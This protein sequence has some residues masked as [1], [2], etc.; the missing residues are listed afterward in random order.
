MKQILSA[1]TPPERSAPSA[2]PPAAA[3]KS[4]DI[5]DIKHYFHV[6]VKRIWLVA[7]CFAISVSVTVV[8]LVKQV[9]RYR[10]Q[11]V[12]LMSKGLPLP[13]SLRERESEPLGDYVG[14]QQR[15]INSKMLIKRARERM[16]RPSAEIASSIISVA[17]FPIKDTAFMVVQVD[18]YDPETGADYANALVD[19]YLVFKA[20]QRRDT[21]QATVTSLSEQADRL[22]R[23]LQK[24]EQTLVSFA[25]E[26]SVVA[27]NNRGNIAADILSG[28]TAQSAQIKKDRMLL[29]VQ[30]PF[31]GRATDDVILNALDPLALS[32]PITTELLNTGGEDALVAAPEGLMEYGVVERSGWKT[33][34]KKQDMLNMKLERARKKYREA[35]PYIQ[36]TLRELEEVNQMMGL[37]V[38]YAMKQYYSQLEA[39]RIKEESIKRVEQS[40]E[41]QAIEVNKK[42]QE[43][44]SIVRQR[45]RLQ[46][47][48]DLI[49]NR[50]KEVDIS[51]GIEPESV[52]IMERAEPAMGPIQPRK[53]QSLFMAALVGI[54]IGLGLVFGLEYIDD[55]LK[56][57]D[58]VSLKLGLRF[59]GV[60]P[61]AKWDDRDLRTHL[62]SNIDQKSGLAEAYRNF[63]SAFMLTEKSFPYKTL[64]ITSAVP[65]E[66]KT[67][68]CMNMGVTLAQAG[69]RI[70]LVDADLRRGGVHKFFGADARLGFAD[71]LTGKAK[72]EAVIQHTGIPNLDIVAAGPYPTNPAEVILKAERKTF[73]DYVS[74]RYDRILFDCP[75]VMATSEASILASMADGVIFVV[76]A[77]H[78]SQ[79]LA[80]MSVK[81]LVERGANMVG[82][83]LN[84]L[85]FSRIGYHYSSYYGYNYYYEADHE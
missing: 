71:V 56:Y 37:E 19:E 28:L 10:S 8:S 24:A 48:Y 13:S 16:L 23:E 38:E 73:I 25:R 58:D 78:T 80:S 31:L 42:Q 82:C 14:T 66:G 26:N 3:S 79:K 34:Q 6:I 27:I 76:W 70:L 2:P 51:V 7:I 54:G 85:E 33:L 22:H 50:L 5:F 18:S 40:W 1:P 62:L 64:A 84:N 29:E 11:S 55:S 46:E 69:E 35:H 83:A 47:L 59:L 53:I 15:I 36:E 17:V 77:G 57:P 43:Y 20:E 65:K 41:E 32:S 67:T 75:P 21:S 72:P 61:S 44:N 52:K 12:L 81:T 49:F 9:P 39:Y 45:D 63:R 68:T 30:Q 74:S 4:F 60:I